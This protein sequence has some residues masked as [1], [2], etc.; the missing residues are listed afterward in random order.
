MLQ[1]RDSGGVSPHKYVNRHLQ[2]Y[3]ITAEALIGGGIV[4]DTLARAKR[5]ASPMHVSSLRKHRHDRT[6]QIHS[7]NLVSGKVNAEGCS[8]V[9][10]AEKLGVN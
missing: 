9:Y 1:W 8:A 5:R 4:R 2:H 10:D 6:Q 7:R 3:F